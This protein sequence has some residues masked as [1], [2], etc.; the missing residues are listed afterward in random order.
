MKMEQIHFLVASAFDGKIVEPPEEVG[1][2]IKG[3]SRPRFSSILSWLLFPTLTWKVLLRSFTQIKRNTGEAFSSAVSSAG[4]LVSQTPRSLLSIGTF[5]VHRGMREG[6]R[7]SISV[8]TFLTRWMNP[9]A[10]KLC[11][12]INA[13]IVV[14][15]PQASISVEQVL[16]YL[17]RSPYLIDSNAV[18]AH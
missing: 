17:Y 15:V 10:I 12:A 18:L 14:R 16:G 11:L 13:K 3:Q 6:I 1:P 5:H 4:N 8:S 7:A 9:D 2:Y